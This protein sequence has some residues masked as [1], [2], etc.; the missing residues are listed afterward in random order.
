MWYSKFQAYVY[1]WDAGTEEGDSYSF[2]NSAT[3]PKQGMSPF[4]AGNSKNAVFVSEKNN[5]NLQVLPVGIITF[6][7]QGSTSECTAMSTVSNPAPAD[8]T[9]VF[10]VRIRRRGGKKQ[11]VGTNCDKLKLVLKSKNNICRKKVRD[12]NGK[13]KTSRVRDLCPTTCESV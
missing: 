8:T 9:S 12:V 2:S 5:G 11:L 1:A 6:E 4:M 3:N 10:Y 13:L 7:L